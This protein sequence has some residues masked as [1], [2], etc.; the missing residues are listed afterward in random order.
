MFGQISHYIWSM[1]ILPNSTRFSEM[2][3]HVLQHPMGCNAHMFDMWQSSNHL[4]DAKFHMDILTHG[5]KWM[6]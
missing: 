4:H 1:K 6:L 2:N 5:L 3:H